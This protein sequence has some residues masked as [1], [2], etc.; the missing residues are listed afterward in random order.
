MYFI[1]CKKHYFLQMLM[2]K[3]LLCDTPIKSY[4][5]LNIAM[6]NII[7]TTLQRLRLYSI[8]LIYCILTVI[9]IAVLFYM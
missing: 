6:Y 4:Q 1:A 7:Q 2:Q 5:M 8:L 3:L 9:V